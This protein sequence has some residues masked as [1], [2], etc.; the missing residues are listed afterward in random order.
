MLPEPSREKRLLRL[1]GEVVLINGVVAGG[2]AT[3]RI[4]AD[5]AIV[6]AVDHDQTRRSALNLLQSIVGEQRGSRAALLHLIR[7]VC[8][9]LIYNGAHE[10]RR[11]RTDRER[12]P[13]PAAPVAGIRRPHGAVV[14]APRRTSVD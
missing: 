7:R 12:T 11:G 8:L 13:E 14:P 10:C 2:N 1:Q 3:V 9:V 4:R 5:D 6:R